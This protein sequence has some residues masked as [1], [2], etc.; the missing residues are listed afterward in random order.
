M[1]YPRALFGRF[2]P[3]RSRSRTIRDARRPPRAED[4]AGGTAAIDRRVARDRAQSSNRACP[5]RIEAPSAAPDLEVDFLQ[6][7]LCGF[8]VAGDTQADA[9]QLRRSGIIDT[10]QCIA[11]TLGDTGQRIDQ[12]RAGRNPSHRVSSG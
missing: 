12:P 10:P 11:I 1:E 8:P 5:L 7:I 4:G 2:D 3:A 9:E 6:D